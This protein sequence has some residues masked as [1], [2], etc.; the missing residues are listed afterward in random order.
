[1]ELFCKRIQMR[2]TVSTQKDN[3]GQNGNDNLNDKGIKNDNLN[4]NQ[5]ATTTVSNIS[6][7]TKNSPKIKNLNQ[8]RN[9]GMIQRVKMNP[10][11]C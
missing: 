9:N 4:S 10:I 6:S 2:K 3:N 5:V 8:W 1:M 7:K 11:E